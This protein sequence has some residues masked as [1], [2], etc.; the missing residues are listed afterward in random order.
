GAPRLPPRREPPARRERYASERI[1]IHNP[2]SG[3]TEFDVYLLVIGT[4]ESTPSGH[5]PGIDRSRGAPQPGAA[6]AP[7]APPRL[8][9]HAGDDFARH[10]GAR[11]RQAGGGGRGP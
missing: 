10:Q 1:F 3:S 5:S 2:P 4:D 11:P 8:R 9:R 7:P 6:A